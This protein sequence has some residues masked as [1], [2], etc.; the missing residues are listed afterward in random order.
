MN[1]LT[2]YNTMKNISLIFFIAF[3][4]TT[5]YSQEKITIKFTDSSEMKGYGRIKMDGSI[6][7]SK[8]QKSEKEIY[9]YNTEKKVKQLTIHYDDS[10][11]SYEYKLIYFDGYNYYELF[12]L[13]KIGKVNLYIKNS[14]IR[15]NPA[16]TGGFG[17]SYSSKLYYI[18]EKN[19]DT[20]LN[21]RQGNTYSKRFRKKIAPKYFS[22]CSDLMNKIN[23]RK[24]FNRYGIESVIDYYNTKCE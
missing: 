11:R 23:T 22:D 3:T 17:M 16:V 5:L 8:E 1:L 14:N 13:Y 19:N 9:S 6:L 10:D 18:S 2:K 15:A 12:E 24:F 4:V 20:I 7:Y 21:L